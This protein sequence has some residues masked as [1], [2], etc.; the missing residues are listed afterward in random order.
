MTAGRRRGGMRRPLLL[1]ALLTAMAAA[2]SVAV[3]MGSMGEPSTAQGT[4]HPQYPTLLQ[5]DP[6][7]ARHERILLAGW[8]C[9]VLV[10]AFSAALLAWGFRRNERSGWPAW[11]V[12]AGFILQAGL[13]SVAMLAYA[14]YMR[15]PSPPLWWALPVPTAWLVYVFWP[16]QLVFVALFVAT[17]D[18]WFWT[19]LDEA[20]FRG[21]VS[22]RREGENGAS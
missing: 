18:R 9:G 15:D 22:A 4:A 7:V 2:A 19:P 16:A 14:R 5:G 1:L 12:A 10:L 3:V 20:R 8:A 13:F 6:G 21:I 11:A 17:F